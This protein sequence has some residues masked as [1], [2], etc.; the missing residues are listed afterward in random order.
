[1]AILEDLRSVAALEDEAVPLVVGARTPV[2]EVVI[3]R[4]PGAWSQVDG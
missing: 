2:I 3:A 1:M 4:T